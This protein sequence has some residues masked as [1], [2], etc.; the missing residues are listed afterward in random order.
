MANYAWKYLPNETSQTQP[1]E[2]LDDLSADDYVVMSFP[3]FSCKTSTKASYC[4]VLMVTSEH[5]IITRAGRILEANRNNE[6]PDAM[7]LR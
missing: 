1:L 3:V 4:R 7:I 5:L 6:I 2:I